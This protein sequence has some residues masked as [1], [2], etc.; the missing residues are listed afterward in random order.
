MNC[1]KCG[2]SLEQNAKFC[3]YCGTRMENANEENTAADVVK[4]EAMRGEEDGKIAA[5]AKKTEKVEIGIEKAK[6]VRLLIGSVFIIIGLFYVLTSG[7]TLPDAV[8][9]ADSYTYIYRGIIETSE[10]LASIEA[11]LGWILVAIGTVID[12]KTLL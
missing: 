10:I 7:S 12:M 1:P 8:F 3:V 11:S 6:L 9:G 4:K 5:S 2:A